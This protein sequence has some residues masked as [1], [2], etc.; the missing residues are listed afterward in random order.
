MTGSSSAPA[1]C[2]F[3]GRE[4]ELRVL[5]AALEDARCGRGRFVLLEAG[6]G[7]TRTTP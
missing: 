1:G 4:Q 5:R 2:D 3:V 6:I 7:K